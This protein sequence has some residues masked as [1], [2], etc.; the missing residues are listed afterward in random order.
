MIAEEN[1]RKAP[2][3]ALERKIKTLSRQV[4]ESLSASMRR[5]NPERLGGIGAAGR[6]R[7]QARDSDK[8]NLL[9]GLINRVRAEIARREGDDSIIATSQAQA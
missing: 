2:S 1:L 9:K 5:F 4:D 7:D 6:Q 3:R 8:R